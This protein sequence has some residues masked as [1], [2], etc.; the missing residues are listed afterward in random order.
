[1]R[2]LKEGIMREVLKRE[3]VPP[4]SKRGWKVKLTLACGHKIERKFSRY[5]G[6]AAVC[7]ECGE[8]V[9]RIKREEEERMDA[10]AKR[11][12]SFPFEQME[13]MEERA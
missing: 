10:I 4:E 13:R 6:S 9:A 3:E 12:M 11:Q 7:R 8:M 5:Q 1:M 2:E